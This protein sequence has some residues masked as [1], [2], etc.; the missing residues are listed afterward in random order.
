MLIFYSSTGDPM[1]L[2]S[3]HGLRDLEREYRRF[4]ESPSQQASF[5]AIV[6]GDPEPYSELLGGLRIE[7]TPGSTQ[8]HITDDR[9]LKLIGSPHDLQ[10][11]AQA[12]SGLED[13]SHHH[14]Y[15]SPISLIIEADEWRANRES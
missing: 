14:F 9:W 11:L 7:K 2:D 3:S 15:A 12:F 1:L 6:V 8:L 13:G 5:P 10:R 4:L